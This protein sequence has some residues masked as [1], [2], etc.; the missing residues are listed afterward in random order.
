MVISWYGQACFRL[1][2]GQNTIAID[3]FDKKIGLTPPSFGADL[4]LVTHEHFDHSNVEAIKGDPFMIDGPGEYEHHGIRVKGIDSYHDNTEGS[5]RGL[6][7]LYRIQSEG[8]RLVHCGDLGQKELTDEQI[9]AMGFVDVLFI[10]VGGFFTINGKEAASIVK[11][12]Q[13][14]VVVPMHY[15]VS[16]LAVNELE[17]V[18]SFV[19]AMSAQGVEPQDK[20]TIKSAKLQPE[21]QRTEV[22]IFKL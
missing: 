2:T 5:E 14:R 13:P 10:P 8:L 17:P 12:V 3:P 9:D 1:Q 6:N 15:K 4:V 19:E 11:K 18:D 21:E 16:S 22:F 7:T 20:L